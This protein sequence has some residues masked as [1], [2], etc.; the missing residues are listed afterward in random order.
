MVREVIKCKEKGGGNNGKG[1]VIMMHDIFACE[2]NACC[3]FGLQY[4]KGGYKFYHSNKI[5]EVIPN[6]W[7][8]TACMSLQKL[9]HLKCGLNAWWWYIM[10]ASLIL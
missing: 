7:Q 5:Q 9:C 8:L 2:E 10:T 3:V 1:E 6:M 4:A